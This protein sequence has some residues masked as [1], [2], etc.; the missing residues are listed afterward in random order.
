[1]VH[2][3]LTLIS[4]LSVRILWTAVH[5]INVT[6]EGF[7]SED[8]RECSFECKGHIGWL[9]RGRAA[10]RIQNRYLLNNNNININ[11]DNLVTD[12]TLIKTITYT[13]I[14]DVLH[15]KHCIN[16][17]YKA[18]LQRGF[19]APADGR[20]S[21]LWRPLKWGWPWSWCLQRRRLFP[22]FGASIGHILSKKTITEQHIQASQFS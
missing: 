17:H 10:R 2:N 21:T 3:D 9:L 12:F 13:S 20:C 14:N 22:L 19:P 8:L 15:K 7:Y 18:V 1:M 6:P 4:G 11:N 5:P 16:N